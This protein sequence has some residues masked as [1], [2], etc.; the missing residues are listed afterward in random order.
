MDQGATPIEENPANGSSFHNLILTANRLRA[1]ARATTSRVERKP[2]LGL[3]GMS[4]GPVLL[5]KAEAKVEEAGD[6]RV[7]DPVVDAVAVSA[8]GEDLLVD[9]ALELVEVR[10]GCR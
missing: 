4:A 3:V 1:Q 5:D 8:G 7:D 2:G 6:A 9:E 10:C